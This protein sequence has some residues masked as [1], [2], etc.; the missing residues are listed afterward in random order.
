M[1]RCYSDDMV[2]AK[3][4]SKSSNRTATFSDADTLEALASPLRIE[5]LQAFAHG[6]RLTVEDIAKHVGRP[7]RS[8]YYHIRKLV[9]AG[10]LVEVDRRLKGRRY[11]SVYS[12][13]AER[14]SI[15]ADESSGVQREAMFRLVSSML[16]K[17]SREFRQALDSDEFDGHEA[18]ATARQQR[19]WLTE[20]DLAQVNDLLGRIEKICTKRQP[21]KDVRLYSIL[22]L[23]V[24]IKE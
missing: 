6:D 12:V 16:R 8:I 18:T 14:L 19:S 11:E 24:P 2:N 9:K 21:G 17:I 5:L 22:S 15:A 7:Q 4:S 3:R 20:K 13:A 10:V 1:G 23:I